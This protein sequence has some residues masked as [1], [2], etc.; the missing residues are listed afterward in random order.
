MSDAF[1]NQYD[2]DLNETLKN[3]YPDI[4]KAIRKEGYILDYLDYDVFHEIR[5]EDK[6]VGFMTF[7]RFDIVENHFAINEAYIIPEYRGNNLLFMHLSNLFLFDNLRYFPRKP[8]KAFVN[9]LLKNDYAIKLDSNLVVSYLK[10][11][12][13]LDEIYKNP[14]IKRFYKKP[15]VLIPYKA[16]LFDLDLCTVLFLD[17]MGNVVKYG[18]F[19][20]LTEPRKYDF[21]KYKCRKKLK[22]VSEK[23]LDEKYALREFSDDK[24][25][26]FIDLKDSEWD[27]LLEVENMIGTEDELVE[28]FVENLNVAGLTVDDGF[29]IRSHIVDGLNSGQLTGTSYFQRMV[30]LMNNFDE[31]DRTIDE[32]G[33]EPVECPFCGMFIPDFA[34]SCMKCGLSIR[35]IDFQKHALEKAKGLFSGF[36]EEIPIE[37]NDELADL[38]VF[39]NRHLLDFEYDEFLKF[40]NDADESL[41]IPQIAEMFLDTKLEEALGSESEFETYFN[42]LIYHVFYNANE[43]NLD[44]SFIYLSQ[45]A[46]LASNE[47]EDKMDL[48]AS[49][50][51]S[52]DIFMGIDKLIIPIHS[53]DV[54]GLFGRAVEDFKIS[55]Y[56]NNH[57][58]ILR[59][60]KEF[61][62]EE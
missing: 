32:I 56:N 34:N 8:T 41:E 30:Y 10:F 26:E 12:V 23:F 57:E 39:Y 62:E 47:S 33:D 61:F 21:K 11:I 54:D 7:A 4:L 2:D 28:D 1:K 45:A 24:V 40:Y 42:Y 14:K 18:D 6:I 27:E 15:D 49:N 48:I 13:D 44:E 29:R 59:E 20:A 53:Y 31:V 46:I 16:N 43:G 35:D 36:D 37:E 19:F 3:R 22:R 50:L 58:E 60:L 5:F 55:K 38:K 25:N 52:F 9:V 17:P 51:H